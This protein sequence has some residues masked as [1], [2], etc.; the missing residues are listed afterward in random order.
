MTD[1]VERAIA[2]LR[3]FRDGDF[4]VACAIACGK[5]AIDALRTVLFERDPS[6]L[7]Q[8]RCRAVDALAALGAEDVLIEFLEAKRDITDPVER[9]GEDAVVNAA[10]LAL[11]NARDRNVFALLL[12]LAHRP[13]L[14]GVIGAL[15]AQGSVEAIPVLVAALEEDA[16]RP[17]AEAALKRVGL[18][19]RSALLHTAYCRLP[20]AER[21]SES[22]ARRRRSALRLLSEIGIPRDIRPTLQPLVDDADPKIA[23]AACRICL[24]GTRAADRREAVHRLL[25]LLD[26]NDWALR[27]EI[28]TV[29]VIHFKAARDLIERR[30][31]ESDS[32]GDARRQIGR[33]LRRVISR[34]EAG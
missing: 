5:P 2:N 23:L 15:G 7:Y 18:P 12:R 27:E 33:I 21:E 17:T 19:A 28:E 10:A 30:L 20:S 25:T 8:A 3:S 14:T 32:D 29:L 24:R 11:A 6:G 26:Y 4:G 16:S 1:D 9:L 22:S 31:D 34:A 13:C